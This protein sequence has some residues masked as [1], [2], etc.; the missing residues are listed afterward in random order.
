[1]RKIV[2]I[3]GGGH[4]KVLI[5]VLKRIQEFAILGYTDRKDNGTILGIPYLGTDHGL[6]VILSSNPSC[7]AAIGIGG[8]RISERRKEIVKELESIGFDL[9][10]I[11]SRSAIV[12]ECVEIGKGTVVF[13]GAVI[14]T[15]TVIG[16]YSILNTNSTVDHDCHIGDYVHI[17]PGVTISGDVRIGNNSLIGAGA[18]IIQGITIADNC[19][20]GA[21]AVVVDDCLTPG[22]YVGV[23]ARR[24]K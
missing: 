7:S 17:A 14:N 21:G 19:L 13:D 16:R 10:P 20:I 4:A 23:P 11:T 22:T 1:M 24:V 2:I 12:N 5:S 3:G 9:P 8:V 18:T 15:G 6:N